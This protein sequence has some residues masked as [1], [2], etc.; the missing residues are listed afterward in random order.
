MSL[1]GK[2][3]WC[4][5]IVRQEVTK[6]LFLKAEGDIVLHRHK[7]LPKTAILAVINAVNMSTGLVKKY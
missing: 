3:G 5:I 2:I 7:L 6:Y 4:R 1:S